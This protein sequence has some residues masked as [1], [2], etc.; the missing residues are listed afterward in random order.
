M[1]KHDK[2]LL[3]VES[4]VVLSPDFPIEVFGK[5]STPFA[6]PIVSKERGI[7]STLF[8]RDQIS[9]QFLWDFTKTCVRENPLVSDMQVLFKLRECH[10]E[11]VTELPTAPNELHL[12]R[13]FPSATKTDVFGGYFDG[14]DFG[15]FV[16]GTNPWNQRAISR[17]HTRIPGSLLA[18]N[19]ENL[20]FDKERDFLSIRIEKPE[21]QAK[22]YS[23]HVTN[24]NPF[25]FGSMTR[26]V[27][28]NIWV[29]ILRK[30]NITFHPL[31]F[32][33]MLYRSISRRLRKLAFHLRLAR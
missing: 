31:V 13:R 30:I 33:I 18:F 32:L 22:L 3:H 16:G 17:L 23:L 1:A 29:S 6:F 21:I 19:S 8:I 20:Y 7:A 27:T 11:K 15:V 9:A 28:V 4:D 26:S 10:P 12:D 14:H 25:F 2:P 5:I 24:K